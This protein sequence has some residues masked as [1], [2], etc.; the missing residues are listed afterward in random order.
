MSPYYI[1]SS[2]EW[3][4][5]SRARRLTSFEHM[6]WLGSVFR[7]TMPHTTPYECPW[8]R[9]NKLHKTPMYLKKILKRSH[10]VVYLLTYPYHYIAPKLCTSTYVLQ[11]YTLFT[12][13]PFG[14][15]T[16]S[17]YFSSSSSSTSTTF[18][19]RRST[20]IIWTP[21]ETW[22]GKLPNTHTI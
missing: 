10:H 15:H 5:K 1:D 9:Y 21:N 11:T 18:L 4:I 7:S 16:S 8:S 2:L 22:S 17:S 14:D 3:F 6:Y 12:L 13:V 19:K 20:L